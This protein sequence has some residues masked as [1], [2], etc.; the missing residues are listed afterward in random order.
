M[1]QERAGLLREGD[2]S[3]GISGVSTKYGVFSDTIN[4]IKNSGSCVKLRILRP[5][6]SL[7][8][9][10]VSPIPP[11]GTNC[12]VTFL[13][14]PTGVHSI[15]GFSSQ[16]EAAMFFDEIVLSACGT[17]AAASTNFYRHVATRAQVAASVARIAL[18]YGDTRASQAALAQVR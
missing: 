3:T 1:A 2:Y 15:S 5:M 6:P 14:Q 9:L 13:H 11:G 7:R 17:R 12:S 10:G 16:A 8:M 18:A 4:L